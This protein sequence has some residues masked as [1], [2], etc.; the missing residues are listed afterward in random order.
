MTFRTFSSEASGSPSA[1]TSRANSRKRSY[2]SLSEGLR[3]FGALDVPRLGVFAFMRSYLMR[4]SPN[5]KDARQ[6]RAE[7]VLDDDPGELPPRH[8]TQFAKLIARNN[9]QSGDHDANQ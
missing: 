7:D 3:F 9:D 8:P 4:D 2:C 6:G 1:P 5:Q